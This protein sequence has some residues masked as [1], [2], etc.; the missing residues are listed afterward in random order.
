[1][2]ASLRG[3]IYRME[4]QLIMP[5]RYCFKDDINYWAMRDWLRLWRFSFT[6]IGRVD[7]SVWAML[8]AVSPRRHSDNDCGWRQEALVIQ[9]AEYSEEEKWWYC[10]LL[11]FPRKLLRRDLFGVMLEDA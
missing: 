7:T 3:V 11:R 5:P 4:A 6:T 2:K 1:M 10:G 9:L 8:C